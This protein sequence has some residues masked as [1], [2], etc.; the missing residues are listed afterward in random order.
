MPIHS[1]D[2]PTAS[3]HFEDTTA[4]PNEKRELGVS[5]KLQAVFE[6]IDALSQIGRA[7][8]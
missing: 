8:V 5:V 4:R 7:H 3:G 1:K 2:Y 6:A